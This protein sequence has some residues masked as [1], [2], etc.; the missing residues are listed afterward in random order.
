MSIDLKNQKCQACSGN[1]PTREENQISELCAADGGT[2]TKVM[3]PSERSL[4]A[5]PACPG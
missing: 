1:T 4:K 3:S 5:L 2:A